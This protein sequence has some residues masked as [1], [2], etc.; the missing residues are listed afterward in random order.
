MPEATFAKKDTPIKRDLINWFITN[1][2]DGRYRIRVNSAITG[3]QDF[4][5]TNRGEVISSA[6]IR[7]HLQNL[8]REGFITVL[9]SDHRRDQTRNGGA[10]QLLSVEDSLVITIEKRRELATILARWQNRHK[11]PSS[12]GDHLSRGQIIPLQRDR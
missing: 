5:L 6:S 10:I 9:P 2:F 11:H 1:S 3:V 7:G 8:A 12:N 4:S